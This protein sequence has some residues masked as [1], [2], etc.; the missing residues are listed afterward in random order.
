M[1][2]P[3]TALFSSGPVA[4]DSTT[5]I[6]GKILFL[7][8]YD[9]S[10]AS[11]RV[12]VYQFLPLLRQR[13]Y[14]VTVRPLLTKRGYQVLRA[15]AEEKRA[16]GLFSA[17]SHVVW[18]YFSR[19]FHL[20]E[21][22]SYDAV[23]VQKDVLPFGM[24]RLLH[25]FNKNIIF[26]F[27]DPIWL[28]HPSSGEKTSLGSWIRRYRE[29]SLL[30]MLRVA[31]VVITDNELIRQ[32][33][34]IHAR[35][36]HVIC[37]PVD[38]SFYPFH[39]PDKEITEKTVLGWIGSPSTTYLLEALLPQIGELAKNSPIKLLNLGGMAIHS[40]DF[41]I[42]NLPW[43]LPAELSAL[44]RMDIGLVP[45]DD[46]PF[47]LY[48]FGYKAVIYFS[49]GVPCLAADVGLNR[50]MI[51]EG[52][53]GLLYGNGPGR[54]F[55]QQTK[56]MISSLE[57]RRTISR[58]G[59]DN[60]ERHYDVKVLANDLA[61]ILERF[62]SRKSTPLGRL[63]RSL[64]SSLPRKHVKLKVL[65]RIVESM[66]LAK[67]GLDVGTGYGG[68]T[69]FLTDGERWT[70]LD[71]EPKRLKLSSSLLKGNF[72]A[73]PAGDFLKEHKSAF[74]RIHLVD[75]VFYFRDWE[76]IM[77]AAAAALTSGG[78]LL[79]SGM[80]THDGDRLLGFRKRHGVVRAVGAVADIEAEEL[81]SVLVT[82][83][84][85]IV[86][87]QFYLGP[88]T[89]FA[90][91]I[92]DLILLRNNRENE[93]LTV[94]LEGHTKWLKLKLFLLF[95]VRQFSRLCELLDQLTPFFP[96]YGYVLVA[97]KKQDVG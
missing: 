46:R 20:F 49:A 79:V 81:E 53:T 59:R 70:Y 23:F 58:C 77:G 80:Q 56:R 29:H 40:P 96:R 94:R 87:K 75:T 76:M 89:F 42:E 45:M 31:K 2:P 35:E 39:L 51:E 15:L 65:M 14:D 44:K 67:A 48:R 27:D 22:L 68:I 7:T 28:G 63:A 52:R 82:A 71:I 91:T 37:S 83:G 66:P 26:D 90:Q 11:S 97:R 64:A 13:G 86:E 24:R 34:Q 69:S 50:T 92:F 93:A 47:N 10:I 85:E 5:Q 78:V 74:D 16:L 84:L 54:S 19:V 32:F 25:L 36:V 18:S 60:A 4:S 1:R 9:D 30:G 8:Q 62:E 73:Q 55:V 88:I 3:S 21:A 41:E 33:A 61:A 12:R 95:V 17:L 38:T 6:C 43:S 57:L 72:V